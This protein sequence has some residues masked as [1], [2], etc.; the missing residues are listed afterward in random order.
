MDLSSVCALVTGASHGV[1]AA[2]AA[3]FVRAGAR[4]VLHAGR[5]IERAR[6]LA[7]SLGS[8]AVGALQADLAVPGA[9]TD[10]FAEADALSDGRLNVVINNAGIFVDSPLAADDAGWQAAWQRTLQVNLIAVAD[11]SRAAVLA[12]RDRGGGSLIAIASR[13]GH[14]G[15]DADHSAYAASKG[16][17]LALTKTLARAYSG[18]G[19]LAFAI[20]PG[21]VDTRMAPQDPATRDLAASE[22]PLGRM[23]AAEEIAAACAFLAS[24]ACPSASGSCLDINGASYVR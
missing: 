17:V 20:A 24:G 16:G 22:I 15:D 11:I 14:R 3:H 7:T 12:F 4:V 1:G 8:G 19:V 18:Q 5:D 6:E 13:A 9:G 10:L 23:A 2:V 21:W